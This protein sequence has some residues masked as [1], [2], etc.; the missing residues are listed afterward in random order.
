MRRR[1]EGAGLR[2]EL[3]IYRELFQVDGGEKVDQSISLHELNVNF[4]SV[5]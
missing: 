2:E 1:N 3:S 4:Y 5:F